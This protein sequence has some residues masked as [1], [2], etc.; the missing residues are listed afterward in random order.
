MKVT[1]S[2]V[3]KQWSFKGSFCDCELEDWLLCLPG[4]KPMGNCCPEHMWRNL[5]SS[6]YPERF[7]STALLAS[8]DCHS[9]LL[10]KYRLS[11]RKYCMRF[12]LIFSVM[13]PVLCNV[14][15]PEIRLD[16]P[17]L[18]F[19]K[20]LKTWFHQWSWEPKSVVDPVQWLNYIDGCGYLGHEFHFMVFMWVLGL[21]SCHSLLIFFYCLWTTQSHIFKLRGCT[22]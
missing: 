9:N 4:L 18:A 17:L 16:W 14:I 21:L 20:A 6:P 11:V 12:Y 22:N 3:S 7:Q 5:Q 2:E 10:E 19:C 15:T 13:A 1:R 8:A